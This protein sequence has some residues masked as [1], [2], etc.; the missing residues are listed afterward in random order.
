MSCRPTTKKIRYVHEG[1]FFMSHQS[2]EWS[3]LV[4]GNPTESPP[5]VDVLSCSYQAFVPISCFIFFFLSH[6]LLIFE[7]KKYQLTDTEFWN[8]WNNGPCA[9]WKARIR[10]KR[11]L[12]LHQHLLDFTVYL[13][14]NDTQVWTKYL[15]LCTCINRDNNWI[16]YSVQ[17]GASQRKK[18]RSKKGRILFYKSGELL[19]CQCAPS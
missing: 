2:K 3:T 12:L 1:Q 17:G 13:I 9:R 6:S 15:Y 16:L 11:N 8:I 4:W 14:I 10:Y 18:H 5:K 7:E 19:V